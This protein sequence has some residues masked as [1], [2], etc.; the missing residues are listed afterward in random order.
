MQKAMLEIDV[1][2]SFGPSS[3]KGVA[4]SFASTSPCLDD[5]DGNI[6]LPDNGRA[7]LIRF[8]LLTTQVEWHDGPHRGVGKLSFQVKPGADA[9][10]TFWVRPRN[11]DNAQRRHGQFPSCTLGTAQ[12]GGSRVITVEASNTEKGDF[13]YCLAVGIDMGKDGYLSLRHDPRI[14]NGGIRQT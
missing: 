9:W 1:T 12:A 5:A 10:E 13:D 3:D 8:H 2:A 6:T 4:L 7:V 11:A 14:K